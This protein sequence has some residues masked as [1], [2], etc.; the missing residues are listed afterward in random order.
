MGFMGGAVH[1]NSPTF[2]YK[3]ADHGFGPV[4]LQPAFK[5]AV[6]RGQHGP[7]I[8]SAGK[9]DCPTDQATGLP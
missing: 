4:A 2:V 1:M 9:C 5:L 7:S 6:Y 8:I 3:Q